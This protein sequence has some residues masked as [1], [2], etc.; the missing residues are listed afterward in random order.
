[1]DGG[2]TTDQAA[3]R[4]CSCSSSSQPS[5][6]SRSFY[7]FSVRTLE[8]GCSRCSCESEGWWKEGCG[9]CSSCRLLCIELGKRR[10]WCPQP[11][12]L[13]SSAVQLSHVGVSSVHS[14]RIPCIVVLWQ[15][16]AGCAPRIRCG[17]LCL[18][19]CWM[20]CVGMCSACAGSCSLSPAA[21]GLA[22]RAVSVT[23]SMPCYLVQQ[24]VS[25]Q[26]CPQDHRC[27][28]PC[29]RLPAV[30]PRQTRKPKGPAVTR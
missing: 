22:R 25:K 13:L 11:L 1:V 21:G 23:V 30:L 3:A 8:F 18:F 5:Q 2:C 26:L 27:D 4:S 29:D 19:A 24:F 12:H 7:V 14:C 15:H 9:M 28:R 6:L 20:F 16:V 17:L 10:C